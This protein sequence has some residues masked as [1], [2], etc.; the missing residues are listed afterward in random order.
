MSRVHHI[1]LQC[2]IDSQ[3]ESIHGEMSDRQGRTL[4]FTGWTEFSICLM[5]LAGTR[6]EPNQLD[7]RSS[8]KK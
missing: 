4:P 6:D 5:E 3:H 8:D 2:E 1:D 7:T